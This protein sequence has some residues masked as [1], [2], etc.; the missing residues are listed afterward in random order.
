MQAHPTQAPTH[1]LCR[2]LAL[3]VLREDYRELELE[4]RLGRRG[5]RGFDVDVGAE[6]F[7]RVLAALGSHTRRVQTSETIAG[8]ARIV[9]SGGT[10]RVILKKRLMNADVD[11]GGGGSPWVARIS[12]SL[13]KPSPACSSTSTTSRAS[14]ALTRHKDRVSYAR[15]PWT[16]D[17][18]RVTTEPGGGVT[19]EVEVELTDHTELFRRPLDE[20]VHAG[21]GI[22]AYLAQTI[23]TPTV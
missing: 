17:A 1:A 23:G 14:S 22:V 13:E 8:G 11:L 9:V 16:I 7:A 6:N 18:T 12:S 3:V 15:G 2:H 19:H 20:I 4:L 10:E 5:V 21:L